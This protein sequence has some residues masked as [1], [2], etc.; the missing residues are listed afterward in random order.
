MGEVILQ[1]I[2]EEEKLEREF[3]DPMLFL[4]A[5]YQSPE[6]KQ[7]LAA[8]IAS[9]HKEHPESSRKRIET[10]FRDSS[11]DYKNLLF[12]FYKE[13][14]LDYSEDQYS[15]NF[16]KLMEDYWSKL[17]TAASIK[18]DPTDP[19]K[20][21][22]IMQADHQRVL[23]HARAAEELVKEGQS[24]DDRVGRI[25]VHFMTVSRGYDDFDPDRDIKRLEALRENRLYGREQ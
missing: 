20:Q 10:A 2:P 23:S 8:R 15:D 21:A 7:A 16:K 18:A 17:F 12:G 22:Q 11:P 1:E 14:P 9:I 19:G 25:L 6:Y 24:P 4:Q 5:F 3:R 13:N